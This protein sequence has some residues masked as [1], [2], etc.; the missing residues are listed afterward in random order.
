MNRKQKQKTRTMYM[1]TLDRQ[2][3]YYEPGK[4]VVFAGW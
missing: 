2:P 3:A 4:Q 1:H